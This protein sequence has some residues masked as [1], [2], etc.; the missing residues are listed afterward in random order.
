MGLGKLVED[1]EIFSGTK[2]RTDSSKFQ[3]CI[4]EDFQKVSTAILVEIY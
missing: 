3:S 4:N 2:R 1:K